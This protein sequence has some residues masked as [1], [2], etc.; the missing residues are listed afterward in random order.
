MTRALLALLALP[1]FAL[2]SAA[3]EITRYVAPGGDDG[4]AG[5]LAAPWAT[6]SGARDGIRALRVGGNQEPVTVLLRGGTYGLEAPFILGPQ[7]SNVTYAAYPD[8][9][10]I[11]S[12][13]QEITGFRPGPGELWVAPLPGVAE[14]RWAFR[15][16]WVNGQRRQPARSPN[17]GFFYVVG[18]AGPALD[19]AGKETDRSHTAFRYKPGDLERWGD[20]DGANLIVFHSWET[21]RLRIKDLDETQKVVTFTGGAAWPFERWGKGQRYYV[22]HIRAALD[23][24]GEWYVDR[25]AGQLLYYP[26]PG[27]DLRTAVVV[28]PRLVRLMEL[29]GEAAPGL[30]VSNVTFLGLAFMYEDYVLEPGGHS[31]PQAVVRAPAAIMVDGAVD[32]R[33]ENCEI[34]RVGDY[35]ISLQKA[36]KRTR[37]VHCRV[38]DT[39]TGGI[40]IGTPNDLGSDL[41][42]SSANIVDNNHIYDTGHVYPGGVGLLVLQSFGNQLTHNEIHDIRYSGISIGWTWGDEFSRCRDNLVE[43]NHVHHVMNGWLDDGGAIYTLG[44]SPG[45]VIRNNLFHDVWP[46][47][48][49]G[50][51]IY[52]DATTNRYLVENNIVY[53]TF[54]GGLMYNNGGHE[55]VIR[56]NV[57]AGSARQALWPYYE[58][59]L[60][61]FRNNII[62]FTQGDLFIPFSESSLKQRLAA[63]EK[64]GDWDYNVY[65]NAANPD[66]SFYGK[67]FADWQALGLDLHSVVADPQFVDAARYDFRLRSTS[68]ALALGFTQIDTREVG[69][70][71]DAAWVNEAR[72]LVY[73]PTVLPPLP[74]PPPPLRVADDFEDTVVGAP[75]ED[76]NDQ[77][78]KG[79]TIRVTD[80]AAAT[81]KHSL[82]F[83]DA[84][85]LSQPWQPHLFYQPH[86]LTGR[87]RESLDLRLEPGAHLFTEWRDDSVY[88]ENI[89][90]T[91]TV[92]PDG[93]V[94]ASGR[95]LLRIPLSQWVHLEIEGAV[96]KDAATTYAVSIT[97]PGQP[98]QRFDNIPNQGTD[99][100]ELHWLGFVSLAEQ[101]AVFYVD[102]VRIQPT[103]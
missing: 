6:I 87:V 28:A 57:F 26:M 101:A 35:A 60:N 25:T 31:D 92:L 24:P 75:P 8:E 15:Q 33:F 5:T 4:Q 66:V 45:S 62:D 18:K 21:S 61:T 42:T 17:E 98:P 32:C 79:A 22:E 53:N 70:Y 7:D 50:W 93:Q 16:L 69:L 52:L 82:K 12:G 73:P 88:P 80:E 100:H 83:T 102:N 20:L 90:P 84:A 59:R 23:A 85:G 74:P 72:D 94:T 27:E 43:H 78:E 14:G 97:L 47:K 36:C 49:I 81:G 44:N 37:I 99:F 19:A 54:S 13:G 10:P 71:G 41:L 11:L 55:H 76:A 48:H 68:P 38:H 46:Y 2:A 58:R 39:G 40:R 67:T 34:A 9:R 103:P 56:N 91:V 30:P 51:G 89:G 95:P 77:E 96:G 29:R 65:Y 64:P 63:N 3:A 86:Y 1:L